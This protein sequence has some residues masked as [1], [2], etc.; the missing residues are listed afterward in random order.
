ME[1]EKVAKM[2]E[3]TWNLPNCVGAIDGKHIILQAPIN[4][5]SE[6]FNYKSQFSIVLMAAVDADYNFI[7]ADVGCQ[8]RIS[9][10]GVFKE[11]TLYKNISGN[12][13]KLPPPKKLSGRH[14]EIPFFFAADSA[15]ALAEHV[16]KPY[17]GEH[18]KGSPKRIFNYRLSR[19]RRVVENAFGIISAVFRVLRKLMLLE[20]TKAELVV[21]AII[22]LHN[23][24]RKHSPNVYTPNTS[25]DYEVEGA[26]IPGS[27]RNDG[28]MNSMTPLRNIPRRSPAYFHKIR[29]ELA[30]YFSN[31][32]AVP[33]QNQHA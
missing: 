13:L 9:D 15:F 32:G 12:T 29:D 1:W 14:M 11:S 8:G 27:W 31:E 2:F 22:H 24:L 7:F 25:M 17:A 33:W 26:L 18:V 30:D 28:T 10:G 19:G 6:F 5:G 20:P 16:M 23:Y 4:S 21:F 3:D